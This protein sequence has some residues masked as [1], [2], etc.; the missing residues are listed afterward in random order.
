M[1]CQ[2]AVYQVTG[3]RAYRGHVP[4]TVF[5][6]RIDSAVAARAVRRGDITLLEYVT[7]DLPPGW[8]LPK[9]WAE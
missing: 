9:G 8:A 5:P 2:A 7:R 1:T 6:A 3:W 4:G